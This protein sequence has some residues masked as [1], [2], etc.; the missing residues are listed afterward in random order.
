MRRLLQLTVQGYKSIKD[1][2]LDL[3]RLNVLIGGNGVGKSNLIGVFKFLRDLYDGQLQVSVAAAGGASALLHFGRKVTPRIQL[4]AV[5]AEEESTSTNAYR[6]ALDPTDQDGFV[7]SE[8]G[9]G[10]HD[11]SKYGRPY[12]EELGA[13]QLE[14]LLKGRPTRI[15]SW[16]TD[17]LASYRVYHFHDTSSSAPVKQTGDVNDNAFLQS[18]A[19]NLAAFLYWIKLKHP[20]TLEL[21]EDIVRQIA[22]FFDRFELTPSR[23]NDSKIRLE[24]RE[25]GSE[26]YFNAHQLSD[27][28][29]RFICMATLLLQ[30]TLPRMILLDEPELGLHPAAIILLTELLQQASQRTQLLVSTQSVTLVNQ[31]QPQDVWVAD[32]EQGA[33]VFR[34]LAK[35]DLSEWTGAYALGELWEKNVLGGRP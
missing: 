21:I 20:A 16:I 14:S 24:W 15:K 12:W 31:L 10:F 33:T 17:D 6:A 18:D 5:F 32:R 1:Q 8:E 34:H 7:F 28:T 13:G 19:R 26:S 30:P 9:A 25:R 27:G 22:P 4:K 2:T 11:T 23:L 3:N 29:L 35:E